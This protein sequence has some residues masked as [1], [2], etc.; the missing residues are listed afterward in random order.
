MPGSEAAA[1]IP[2]RVCPRAA[3]PDAP[4]RLD[5][6][7]FPSSGPVCQEAARGAAE[8]V[9]LAHAAHAFTNTA[10]FTLRCGVC[11]VCWNCLFGRT[12]RFVTRCFVTRCF[13]TR[14]LSKRSAASEGWWLN[15][16]HPGARRAGLHRRCGLRAAQRRLRSQKLWGET[17]M[18]RRVSVKGQ[19]AHA[20]TLT[21]NF[22]LR[23]RR[24]P[25]G[26]RCSYSS[27]RSCSQDWLR[28]VQ[29]GPRQDPGAVADM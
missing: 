7:L 4:E 26:A 13:V 15:P 29:Q 8:L 23:C 18:A 16:R 2:N 11:Q 5:V 6:T 22:T 24:L 21:A 1:S 17:C 14:C 25:G 10:D 20:F 27:A 3:W 28:F 19:L 12:R 9:A